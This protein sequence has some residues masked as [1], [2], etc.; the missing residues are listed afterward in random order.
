MWSDDGKGFDLLMVPPVSLD[1]ECSHLTTM[2]VLS[3]FRMWVCLELNNVC[4]AS[5]LK[6]EGLDVD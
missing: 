2:P 4:A 3:E 5:V 1:S 6:A